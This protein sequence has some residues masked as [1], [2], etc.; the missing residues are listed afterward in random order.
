[1]SEPKPML[2]VCR[3]CSESIRLNE[4]SEEARKAGTDPMQQMRRHLVGCP[5][6]SLFEHSRNTGWLLDLLAFTC[7]TEPERLAK[8]QRGVLEWLAAGAI[9]GKF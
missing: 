2:L 4:D 9:E 3:Y 5:K 7:P 1:M 6:F 8:T